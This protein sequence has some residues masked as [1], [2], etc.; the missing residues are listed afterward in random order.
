MKTQIFENYTDF[1]SRE[2][3]SING[4][5]REFAES[6]PYFER[7]NESDEGCWNCSGCSGCSDCSDCSRCSG[8]S[9]CSRK[10]GS[11]KSFFVPRIPK[12]HSAVLLAASAE[13]SLRMSKWHT[14]ETT[15]C[16]AGWV[17]HLAGAAG[18]E[19]ESKTSTLFAAMQIYHLSSPG[20][21]VSPCRFFET[22]E[23]AMQ[24][25]KR[26]AELESKQPQ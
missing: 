5:S 8:C 23:K 21:S 17:V 13:K 19:L 20:I 22:N 16:R 12:I 3:K 18:K 9:D 14:C 1:L 24:D 25:I 10:Q 6:H 7:E 26:C 11:D 2:D 4:V 15:H